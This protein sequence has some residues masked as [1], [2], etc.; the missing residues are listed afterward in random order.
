MYQKCRSYLIELQRFSNQET[1]KRQTQDNVASDQ[2]FFLE[3]W[4][5]IDSRAEVGKNHLFN[6]IAWNL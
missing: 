2:N 4:P 6:A 3:Q 1:R 5:Q